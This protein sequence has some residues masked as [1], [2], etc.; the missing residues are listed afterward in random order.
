LAASNVDRMVLKQFSKA[1]PMAYNSENRTQCTGWLH[2][3]GLG[4]D[5][6][7]VS[8]A[9]LSPDVTTSPA[10]PADT[11]RVNIAHKRNRLRRDPE[12][13]RKELAAIYQRR[14]LDHDLAYKIAEELMARGVLA[15]H[16]CD[17][18]GSMEPQRPRPVLA[19]VPAVSFLVGAAFP[20][21]IVLLASIGALVVVVVGVTLVVLAL[22][23]WTAAYIGGAKPVIGAGRVEL[24]SAVAMSISTA[25]GAT[26]G[27]HALYKFIDPS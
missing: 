14:G 22:R 8:T 16:A 25:I 21:L 13:E 18:L 24:C 9:S 17:E 15:T 4:A 23:G 7:T 2:A 19:L 6:G 26:L 3:M 1:N 27:I 5:D 12:A 20:L 11:Q 10:M